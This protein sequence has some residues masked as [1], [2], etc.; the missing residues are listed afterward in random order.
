M[1]CITRKGQHSIENWGAHHE[2]VLSVAIT[3][4]ITADILGDHV[5]G[6]AR[7]LL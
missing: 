1:A 2:C 4:R 5:L 6:V 3:L 7:A